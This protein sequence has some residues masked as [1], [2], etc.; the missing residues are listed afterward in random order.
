V[1][2]LPFVPNPPRAVARP[3]IWQ[4]WHNRHWGNS[5]MGIRIIVCLNQKGSVLKGV[6]NSTSGR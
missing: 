5:R 6:M 2:I 3:G 1:P 4:N